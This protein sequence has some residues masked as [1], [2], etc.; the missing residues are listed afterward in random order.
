ME[1]Q[2]KQDMIVKLDKAIASMEQVR[3]SAQD[4]INA[5]KKT[6]DELTGQTKLKV[7]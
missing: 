4:A 3:D 1:K 7:V 2:E 5:M 6:R